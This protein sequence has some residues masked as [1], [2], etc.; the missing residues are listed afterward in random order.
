MFY[1]LIQ[2][3]RLTNFR[4]TRHVS[5]EGFSQINFIAGENGVGKTNILDAVTRFISPVGLKNQ[6]AKQCVNMSYPDKGWGVALRVC[7]Q[8]DYDLLTGLSVHNAMRIIKCDGEKITQEE[9]LGILPCLWLTPVGEKLFTEDAANI[10]GYFH[11]MV[12]LFFSDFSVYYASYER[13]CKQRLKIL[14]TDYHSDDAWLSVIE[15]EIARNALMLLGMR[16]AFLEKFYSYKTQYEGVLSPYLP[17]F[18]LVLECAT[19]K[20]MCPENYAHILKSM[21][22]DDKIAK[23]TLFGVHRAKWGALHK[24]KNI[25]INYCSVGE[26]KSVLLAVLL[27]LN[28]ALMDICGIAPVILLD[29]AFAHFDKKRIE[30]LHDYLRSLQNNIFLTGTEFHIQPDDKQALFHITQEMMSGAEIGLF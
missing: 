15:M 7:L 2:K 30:F 11:Y 10:R 28:R 16:K 22:S 3:L 14:I 5:F 21:R 29:D 9:A 26:Q 27:I 12:G 18:E 8:R 20:V 4:N 23:R 1:P 17:R 19:E 24:D 13:A 25:E 6:Y